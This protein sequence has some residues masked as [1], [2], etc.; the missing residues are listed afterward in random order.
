MSDERRAEPDRTHPSLMSADQ[1]RE[2]TERALLERRTLIEVWT[3]IVAE[4]QEDAPEA[5][6][7]ARAQL[8]AS[9]LRDVDSVLDI[10]CLNMDLERCLRPGTGYFPCD[11][12][13]RDERTIVVDLNREPPPTVDAQAVALLGVLEYL[14]DVEGLL[15]ALA[16]RYPIAVVTYAAH[17]GRRGTHGNRRNLFWFNEYSVEEIVELFARTGW[18]IEATEIING[19]H[20]MW[21]L[22][23]QPKER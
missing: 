20:T 13:A 12:I 3:P 10:G 17:R 6:W 8:A 11:V 14:F 9:L 5:L 16:A 7:L 4:A 15:S 19:R 1:R 18:E 2:L 21:R 23:S 22:V